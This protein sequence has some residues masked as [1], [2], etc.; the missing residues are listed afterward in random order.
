MS[1]GAGNDTYVVDSPL[2]SVVE[3]PGEGTDIVQTTLNSYDGA[4]PNVENLTFNGA[5]NFTGTG[6][7]WQQHASAAAAATTR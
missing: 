1:G 6:N 4:G 7:D 2:D 3:N 5:G